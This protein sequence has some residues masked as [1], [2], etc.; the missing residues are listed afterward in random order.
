MSALIFI[1]ADKN[2][3][4]KKVRKNQALI[5]DVYR[6]LILNYVDDI[7]LDAFTKMS[8]NNMLYDLDPYTV[9]LEKEERS[10]IEM[11]TKGKYGGVGIQIGKREKVLTVISPMENSP[12]KRAGIIS[13]DKIIKI[14]DKETEGLSMDDAAK[15]IRGEKGSN[16]VLSIQRVGESDLVEYNLTRENIKVKDISFSGMLDDQT[17]YIRLIRFS[18]NSDKEMKK[19]LQKLLEQNMT[20]LVLDLRDNPG[21]LLNAAV[22]ILDLFID[23]GE[24]LVWTEGKTQKSKR[25]YKSK[26]DPLVPLDVNVTVLVNQGSASASEIVAGA[27]QDLDRAV[28]IGRSTFGKG[29]VQTVF[30]IDKDRSLKITTAKYYIPSGRLIQKPGYLPDEIL[31]D[32]TEQDSIFY[33]K[34]G[35]EVSGA[36]GITPDHVVE[37][38]KGSPILSASWRQGLFFNFVQKH[39]MDYETFENVLDDSSIME[40]F[41]NY[42]HASDLDIFMQGESNYLDMKEMLWNLDSTNIQIQGALEILDSYFEQIALTQF[43]M[44]EEKLHHWLMVEFADYF[45]DD[46]G[47]VKQ[48]AIQDKDIQKALTLLHDP[49]VYE[50]V[51]LPQLENTNSITAD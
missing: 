8:I 4:Y 14:D 37:L 40:Q 16:V 33:T 10:G 5:N 51:F 25:K 29:L 31:A 22:N 12:A 15:L 24:M 17:G 38:N 7:D 20:G 23:K 43:E 50:N 46:E 2:D 30:N 26:T 21:G 13:G 48:S 3:I 47:R 27:L 11:L 49:V 18:R 35:R 36:G 28:V 45:H 6:N 41:E 44:E 42:L 34:G 39:K 9:Y 19:A 32:T 1:G